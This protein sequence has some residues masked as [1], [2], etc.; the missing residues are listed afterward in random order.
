MNLELFRG[1]VATGAD[2][3]DAS[4]SPGGNLR[5]EDWL[6]PSKAAGIIWVALSE[7][8]IGVL[9]IVGLFICLAV[10]AA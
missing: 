10:L 6:F 2:G 4:G 3:P 7:V 5:V 9:L 8:A 1:A